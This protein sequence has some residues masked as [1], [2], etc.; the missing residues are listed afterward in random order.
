MSFITIS[1]AFIK[2][3]CN[4]KINIADNFDNIILIM[5]NELSIILLIN[6]LRIIGMCFSNKI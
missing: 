3:V 6:E 1:G 4:D 5:F 2:F